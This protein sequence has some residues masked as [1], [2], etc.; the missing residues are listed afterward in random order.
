MQDLRFFTPREIHFGWGSSEILKNLHGRAM[1]VSGEHVWKNIGDFVPV[2]GPVFLLSRSTPAGEPKEVDVERIAEFFT[3]NRGEVILAVGGGSVIDS[4]KIAWAFY[5]HPE[6]KW[7]DIYARRIPRLRE[8]A[9][10]VA[11]ETTSGTGTGISAAAVVISEEGLK[12]GIVTQEFIPDI[13]V[14]DPN[15]VLSMPKRTAIYSGMDALSHAIEA[16]VSKIDNIPA[17][18]MA[19]KAIELIFGNIRESVDGDEKAR[20]MMHY[21]NMMAAMGFANSRLGLCHAASHKIGGRIGMEHGKVNAILLPHFIRATR[22]Y[23]G[24]YGEIEKMLGVDDLAGAIEET[25]RYFGIPDRI[26]DISPWIA[27]MADEIMKDPLMRTNPGEMSREEV[28]EFLLSV[29]GER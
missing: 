14:Y 17:D 18:T 5:E 16:Y 29:A 26:P 6:L 4:A 19:L 11:V 23:T 25:N 10:F 21:A 22:K 27:D 3:E 2:D 20:A 13:A 24:R 28:V 15:L 9:K 12:H 7:E 1:I 8:K